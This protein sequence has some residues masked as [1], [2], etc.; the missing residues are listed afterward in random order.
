[1]ENGSKIFANIF[2]EKTYTRKKV[3][4]D[5]TSENS[6]FSVWPSGG[7][8]FTLFNNKDKLYYTREEN[9][10]SVCENEEEKGEDKSEENTL[11]GS[12]QEGNFVVM[13]WNNQSF[14]V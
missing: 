8:E 13:S 1:M 11:K 4:G 12:M 5:P 9:F 10:Q 14:P 7:S 2:Q 6:N 3:Q